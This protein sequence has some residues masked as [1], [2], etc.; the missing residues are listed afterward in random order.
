MDPLEIKKR[1]YSQ[2]GQYAKG[3]GQQNIKSRYG[4]KP[5]VAPVPG[6]EA[7]PDAGGQATMDMLKQQGD[8]NMAMG[9]TVTNE[10]K[11]VLA[12]LSPEDLRRLLGEK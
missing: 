4:K 9:D 3:L 2:M 10:N 8:A 1:L 11:D 7:K 12:G 6:A 5:D